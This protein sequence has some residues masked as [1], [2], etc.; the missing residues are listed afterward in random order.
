[1]DWPR[2][3]SLN[4]VLHAQNLKSPRQA[5][6]DTLHMGQLV[7]SRQTC[8][9]FASDGSFNTSKILACS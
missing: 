4:Q 7:S 8:R 2:A 5:V 6:A 3:A 1:M 9:P